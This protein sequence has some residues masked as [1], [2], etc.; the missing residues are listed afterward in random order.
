MDLPASG[1]ATSPSGGRRKYIYRYNIFFCFFKILH[2]LLYLFLLHEQPFA[3]HCDPSA[4]RILDSGA[5]TCVKQSP[6]NPALLITDGAPCYRSL[7]AK[8]GWRHEACNHSKGIFCTKKRI[9][10]KTVLIHTGGV[11]SM[12]KLSKSAIPSSLATRVN[13]HVNPK[14]GFF[15]TNP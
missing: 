10:N 14:S 7:N 3:I 8:F 12:W 2:I 1:V 15:K 9:E 4:A 13:G 11:D 6:T 5:L